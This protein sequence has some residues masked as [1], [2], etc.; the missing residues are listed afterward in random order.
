[1][2]HEACRHAAS[3][4]AARPD[5]P[6][7]RVAVNLSTRQLAQPEFPDVVQAVLDEFGLDRGQLVLEMTESILIDEAGPSSATLETLASRGVPLALDDFGTGYSSLGYLRRFPLAVLKL[8]RAFLAG[9]GTDP[10]AAAIVGAV[11]G[12]GAG[13][14]ARRRW[15]RAWRPR[16]RR[17]PWRRWAARSRRASTSHDR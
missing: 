16:S 11:A 6:P 12:M 3:W 15:R 1:M 14:G 10:V 5:G 7:L 17:R 13:A 2:L 9:L 8:D 4:N